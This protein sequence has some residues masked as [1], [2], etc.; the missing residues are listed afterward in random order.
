MAFVIKQKGE[1]MDK[2]IEALKLQIG[3]KGCWNCVN[4][5]EPMRMCEWAERGGDGCVH[6]ICPK[7]ERR[8]NDGYGDKKKESNL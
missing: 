7:W 2:A 1:Q 4:Q 6:W 3:Y 8:I 5:I